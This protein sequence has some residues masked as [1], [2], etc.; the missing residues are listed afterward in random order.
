MELGM[1][2]RNAAPV[3][4]FDAAKSR[5]KYVRQRTIARN[6]Q[7][8]TEQMPF[9]GFVWPI[10]E[11]RAVVQK[12]VIVDKLHISWLQLHRK[13]ELWAIGEFVKKVECFDV[14]RRQWRGLGK[15]LGRVDVLPLIDRG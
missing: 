11:A 3:T 8:Q 5:C 10:L 2:Y 4:N 15:A 6:G 13:I 14:H 1:R 9:L 7:P 12:R